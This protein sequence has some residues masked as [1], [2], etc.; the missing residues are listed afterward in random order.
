LR[1]NPSPISAQRKHV[2]DGTGEVVGE[3]RG[4]LRPAVEEDPPE[5]RPNRRIARIHRRRQPVRAAEGDVRIEAA[6]VG[7]GLEGRGQLAVASLV[8]AHGE[9]LRLVAG[10]A[11]HFA[12]RDP[13]FGEAVGAAVLAS[14]AAAQAARRVGLLGPPDQ[15]QFLH[16]APTGLLLCRSRRAELR[17]L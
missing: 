4:T 2:A 16:A 15:C 13:R 12:G 11:M 14:V 9:K 1:L 17:S 5:V 7:E 10:E 8:L 6:E 3:R